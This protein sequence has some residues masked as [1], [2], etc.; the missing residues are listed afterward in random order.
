MG[1]W[2]D[3]YLHFYIYKLNYFFGVPKFLS[4]LT[5]QMTILWLIKKNINQVGHVQIDFSNMTKWSN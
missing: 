3:K 4:D 2:V 1:G 5:S